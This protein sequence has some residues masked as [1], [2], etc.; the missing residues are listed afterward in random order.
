MWQILHEHPHWCQPLMAELDRRGIAYCSLNPC[1]S[2]VSLDPDLASS[3]PTAT[4]V[5]NRMSPSAF[6][7]DGLQGIFYTLDY[8]LQMERLGHCVINGS[9]AYGYEISKARQLQL[10]AEL[11]L[12]FPPSV[13][14]NHPS[15]V[16]P[17]AQQLQFPI[18]FK[19]NVGGS[20][21]GIVR[22]DTPEALAAAAETGRLDFGADHS[23]LLQE[24]IPARGGCITRVEMLGGEFLYA[25]DVHLS[26]EGF[27]LCPADICQTADGRSLNRPTCLLDAPANRLRVSQS[28]ADAELVADCR[29]IVAAAG[30]DVGGIE[31]VV[32]DRTGQRYYYDINALSNFV[33]DAPQV[34]GFDPT[35]RLADYLQQ[36]LAAERAAAGA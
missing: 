30:I 14:V 33:A 34:V 28:A 26:G 31:S 11:G 12:P 18:L 9:R 1:Q 10:L 3:S 5:F 6:L 2:W 36:R 25:I 21:A 27:N 23:A 7:R 22:F 24:W 29:Q 4:V 32:D 35:E 8:L 20:G 17:A 19:A 16:M 13:L 15:A